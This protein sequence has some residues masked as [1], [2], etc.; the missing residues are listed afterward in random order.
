VIDRGHVGTLPEPLAKCF[1]QVE[2]AD[3]NDRD[4][5]TRGLLAHSRSYDHV[6]LIYADAL[7]LGCEAGERCALQ[8][9]RSVLIVNGRRR[10]FRLDRQLRLRLRASRWLAHTRIVERG[11]AI[12]VQPLARSLAA[13]DRLTQAAS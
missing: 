1:G 11:F 6:V 13:W 5:W 7:G 3:V 2:S 9:G 10:T 12:A 8:A 4:A